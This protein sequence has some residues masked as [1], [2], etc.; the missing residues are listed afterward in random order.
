[1]NKNNFECVLFD[2]ET[3]SN[4]TRNGKLLSFAAIKFNPYDSNN[5]QELLNNTFH[6]MFNLESQ[7]YRK[8]TESTMNW[9]MEQDPEV[10]QRNTPDEGEG[11]SIVKSDEL[12][13]FVPAFDA[14][15]KEN[16]LPKN[17]HFFARGSSFDVTFLQNI[18]RD[19]YEV[20]DVEKVFPFN[21]W[22]EMDVRTFIK[23]ATMNFNARRLPADANLLKGFKAHD[24]E[25][26]VCKDV[27][28]IQQAIQYAMLGKDIPDDDIIMC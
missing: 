3:M 23:A 26:D 21:F 12:P 25:H 14:W 20:D 4:C 15:V 7:T 1:M 5:L 8:I 17:T 6:V 22:L 10:I 24:P 2:F 19:Y 11:Y 18:Y 9:W 16:N 13:E 27:I 28:A